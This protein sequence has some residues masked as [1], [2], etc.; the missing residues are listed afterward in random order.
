LASGL[1]ATSVSGLV[2]TNAMAMTATGDVRPASLWL[3]CA[4]ESMTFAGPGTRLSKRSISFV[5][6]A[7]LQCYCLTPGDGEVAVWRALRPTPGGGRGCLGPRTTQKTAAKL[8][9]SNFRSR[10]SWGLSRRLIKVNI[11][12]ENRCSSARAKA[13]RRGCPPSRY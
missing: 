4:A 5:G 12:A 11:G 9:G 8:L 6:T 13:R 2:L 7:L 3:G 1:V 10:A